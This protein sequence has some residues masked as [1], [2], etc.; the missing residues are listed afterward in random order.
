MSVLLFGSAG[1]LG[2]ALLADMAGQHSLGSRM[3]LEQLR[4]NVEF[5]LVWQHVR[6][7]R[8]GVDRDFVAAPDRQDG[9]QLCFEKAPM[10]GL[11]TRMQMVMGHARS[12]Y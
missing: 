3:N 6:A 8:D 9:L 2:R 10:A 11:G 5:A 7:A 12:F 1:Q 4:R